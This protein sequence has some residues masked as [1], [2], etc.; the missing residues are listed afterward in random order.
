MLLLSDS[1]LEFHRIYFNANF[2]QMIQT[3]FYQEESFPGFNGVF[4]EN[5]FL[6][7]KC[8]VKLFNKIQILFVLT[9]NIC[10]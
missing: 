1:L 4:S 8:F 5:K 3:F 2:E 7:R 6:F 9:Q 10:Q